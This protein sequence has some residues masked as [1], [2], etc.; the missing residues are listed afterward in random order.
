MTPETAAEGGPALRRAWEQLQARPVDLA[1]ALGVSRAALYKWAAAGGRTPAVMVEPLAEQLR[2]H[3]RQQARERDELLAELAAAAATGRGLTVT[4]VRKARRSARTDQLLDEL[5]AGA[6]PLVHTREVFARDEQGRVYV[7]EELHPGPAGEDGEPDGEPELTPVT[8]RGLRLY[9]GHS[10]EGMARRFGCRRQQLQAWESGREQIPA[11]RQAKVRRELDAAVA[12]VDLRERRE[13]LGIKQ[14]QLAEEAG[15][16]KPILSRAET[17]NG[18]PLRWAELAGIGHALDRA[19]R[20]AAAELAAAV[21][22]LVA[23]VAAAEPDGLTEAQLERARSHGR[24]RGQTG[25]PARD[26]QVLEAAIRGRRLTWRQTDVLSR[27]GRYRSA[28]RLHLAGGAGV[29][30]SLEVDELRRLLD[31]AGASASELSREVGAAFGTVAR[32]LRGERRIPPPRVAAVRAALAR[33]ADRPRR[34]PAA[35]LLAAAAAEPGLPR[36]QLLQ[37]AGY[38]KANATATAALEQLVAEGRL[39]LEPRPHHSTVVFPGPAPAPTPARMA[40]EELRRLRR[41]AGLRQRDLAAAVGVN[42]TAV[43]NWERAG[44]PAER[45]RS[46]EPL[47]VPA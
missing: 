39:H 36:W 44:L 7:R 13:R 24:V 41:A 10:L 40:G 19:E 46:V 28:R 29:T 31:A 16:P 17:G 4:E 42:Q 23:L 25:A 20:S 12:R 26:A 6:L 27:G 11:G 15:L 32:W 18:R 34:D 43:A 9:A 22:Q 5:R 33:L 2:E 14:A 30:D 38:G 35:A 21:E 3:T 8:L 45:R 37:R 1:A 47:L